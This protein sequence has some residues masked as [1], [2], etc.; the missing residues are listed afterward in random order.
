MSLIAHRLQIKKKSKDISSRFRGDNNYHIF[1]VLLESWHWKWFFVLNEICLLWKYHRCKHINEKKIEKRSRY[2]FLKNYYLTV[3][4]YNGS[5]VRNFHTSGRKY[6]P[7]PIPSF[8]L[9]TALDF[10]FLISVDVS[11]LQSVHSDGPVDITILARFVW[12]KWMASKEDI[13]ILGRLFAA[14]T[15]SMHFLW[16]CHEQFKGVWSITRVPTVMPNCFE[17]IN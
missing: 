8:E 13:F 7:F 6:T 15:Y 16:Q 9:E 17:L 10:F 5:F 14:S 4:F 1:I 11:L 3:H 12:M 2:C